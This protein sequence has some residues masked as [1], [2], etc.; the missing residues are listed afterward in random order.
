[1]WANADFK[2]LLESKDYD[3]ALTEK[4]IDYDEFTVEILKSMQR[5]GTKYSEIYM[6]TAFGAGV[7]RLAV[8]PFSYYLFTSHAEETAEMDRMVADGMTYREAI[9]EMIRKYRS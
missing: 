6:D 7:V 9:H 3:K 4:L 8:D 5:N 2:I 1:M